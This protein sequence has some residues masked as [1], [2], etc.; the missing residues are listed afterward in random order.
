MIWPQLLNATHENEYF[1]YIY[2]L[3]SDPL[4]KFNK[5]IP[6]KIM[7]NLILTAGAGV[8]AL[9]IGCSNPTTEEQTNDETTQENA[10]LVEE[11]YTEDGYPTEASSDNVTF[12]QAPAANTG[13]TPKAGV[14]LN[15]PHGEPG[16]RCEINVGDPLPDDG[17]APSPISVQSPP[18]QNMQIQS[19]GQTQTITPTQSPSITTS[20]APTSIMT[21]PAPSTPTTGSTPPG[22]NP[23]HGEPG[24]DCAVP[25]GSPLPK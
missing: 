6:N 3:K 20:P 15:P 2:I 12:E 13:T 25:V 14:K 1:A 17:G 24:H 11:S 4:G 10:G 23:P 22:M 21:S 19:S 7:K 8:F 18:P 5:Q 16:H 9:V